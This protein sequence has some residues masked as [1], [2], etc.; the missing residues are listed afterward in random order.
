MSSVLR[1]NYG[2]GSRVNG[3]GLNMKAALSNI[4]AANLEWFKLLALG[5]TVPTGGRP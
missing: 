5:S 2:A 3:L 4:E 1:H